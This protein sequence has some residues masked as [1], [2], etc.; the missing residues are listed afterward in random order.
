M[1]SRRT[2]LIGLGGLVA[3]GGALIGTGAFTTVEA[4]RTVSVE[5]AGDADAFLS[6]T[7]AR[8]DDEY[9]E[10]TD[11]TIQINLD[12]ND[13]GASGLNQDAITTFRNLVTVA[14]NGTQ[15][16]TSVTLEFT[17]T[18]GDVDAGDTFSFPVDETDD[19]GEDTVDNG[20]NVL[21]GN[22]DIPSD[23]GAGDSVNFGLEI[24]LIDGGDDGSLPDD[25]DY[26]LTITADTD[27]SS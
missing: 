2:V 5:T 19:D 3:G 11:G 10:Q 17:E 15:T 24:D 21:T 12:G 22:N 7:P 14:N 25:G 8:D 13:E 20:D 4:E 9:V 23:L 18:P 6:L 16:V 1:A 27:D 26:T